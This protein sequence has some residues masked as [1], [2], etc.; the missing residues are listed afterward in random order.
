[1]IYDETKCHIDIEITQQFRDNIER[2]HLD[3]TKVADTLQDL[4]ASMDS[5][6][7]RFEQN[8][9]E[10]IRQLLMDSKDIIGKLKALGTISTL[11]NMGSFWQIWE[12]KPFI[13]FKVRG[14]ANND[15]YALQ[16]VEGYL[17]DLVNNDRDTIPPTK[18]LLTGSILAI[19]SGKYGIE[20]LCPNQVPT[21]QMYRIS[22]RGGLAGWSGGERLTGVIL[23]YLSLA[24][25][26]TLRRSSKRSDSTSFLLLDNPYGSTTLQAFIDLQFKLARQFDIQLISS[27][28]TKETDILACYPKILGMRKVGIDRK[29]NAIYVRE[30][31]DCPELV[32]AFIQNPAARGPIGIMV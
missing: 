6:L 27:T 13:T 26:V 12:G 16:K 19:L 4:V 29:T 8:R 22:D 25:L 2:L 10:I 9:K 23:F 11:P 21:L 15:E 7:S 1:M 31:Q 30:T 5:H 14:E 17:L 20:T 18:E 28:C 32:E 3:C 24:R